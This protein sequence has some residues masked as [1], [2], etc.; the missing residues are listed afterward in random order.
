MTEGM[1]EVLAIQEELS[2]D[3]FGTDSGFVQ[4]RESYREERKFW[5]EGGPRMVET[6]DTVVA[7]PHGHIPVRIYSSNGK[8]GNA[9]AIFIHGGGFVVGSPETHDRMMRIFAVHLDGVVVAVDYRL[10]PE[11]KF[12][13]AVEECAS[14]VKF[15]S[16]SGERFGIDPN[17][18]SLVGD[19]GGA[20][21]SLATT[22]FLR[23]VDRE[24]SCIKAL[25]LYYGLFGLKDSASRRLL[26]G[27]WDG[28]TREDLDYYN[29]CYLAKPEDADSPYFD[30]LAADLS[31]G[32][33]PTYIAVGDL[34]PLL[35][36]SLALSRILREKG[37][38]CDCRI[39]EGLL[40]AFLHYSRIL[41][42]AN[43]ALREGADFMR[44]QA[45]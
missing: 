16:Q 18:L 43:D 4:M 20:N 7:G 2:R 32:I 34:D 3:A 17:R 42:E 11:H 29:S 27:P 5:N 21:L 45:C 33:P 12:P 24:G 19:S 41:D 13:V 28:L 14:V 8:K 9:C 22:L 36:D 1:K 44:T 15:L 40:H 39:Y 6:T 38:A 30:C 25:V 35:D 23:D 31:F 37:V 10:A 26:G